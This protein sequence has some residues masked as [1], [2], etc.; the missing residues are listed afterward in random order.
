SIDLEVSFVRVGLQSGIQQDVKRSSRF[1]AGELKGQPAQRAAHLGFALAAGHHGSKLGIEIGLEAAA[2]RPH[3]FR[4]VGCQRTY[5]GW[6][7]LERELLGGRHQQIGKRRRYQ[8]ER[9]VL[10]FRQDRSLDQNLQG[11]ADAHVMQSDVQVL[12]SQLRRAP[13]FL[14]N[15]SD[16][17]DACVVEIEIADLEAGQIG[18][19]LRPFFGLALAELGQPR[20][21]PLKVRGAVGEPNDINGKSVDPNRLHMH[22]FSSR[23]QNLEESDPNLEL[24]KNQ[25]RIGFTGGRSNLYAGDPY[26]QTR[27]DFG[28]HIPD[29]N[30]APNLRT[31]GIRLRS[32]LFKEE[33]VEI[34]KR[35][36][37]G[38]DHHERRDADRHQ[39]L[40]PRSAHGDE[41][42]GICLDTRRAKCN[43]ATADQAKLESPECQSR[44]VAAAI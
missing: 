24:G 13:T 11:L 5:V 3:R 31:V 14:R 20:L 2:L 33:R 32:G 42:Y 7:Y 39:Y 38:D 43:A 18:R 19:L 35:K 44:R 6:L 34:G 41:R 9:E 40:C 26:R 29:D 27:Q 10:F 12:D 30:P 21:Q 4:D 17:A 36:S 23:R 1:G 22:L 8:V 15:L 16:E 28:G 25:E 37:R